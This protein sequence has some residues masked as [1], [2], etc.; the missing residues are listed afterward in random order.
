MLMVRYWLT[1]TEKGYAMIATMEILNRSKF[2]R[3][4]IDKV[5]AYEDTL[6]KDDSEPRD[7]HREEELFAD[8]TEKHR[9]LKGR[10]VLAIVFTVGERFPCWLTKE[11]FDRLTEETDP[12]NRTSTPHQR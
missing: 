12:S 4:V 1:P 7:V 9:K 10:N 2:F 11:Q 8:L 5:V 3:L 6:N